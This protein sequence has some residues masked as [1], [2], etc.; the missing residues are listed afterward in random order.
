MS[1]VSLV[2]G[3]SKSN[4]SIALVREDTGASY[5][6]GSSAIVRLRIRKT[7]TIVLLNTSTA[8]VSGSNYI[9]DLGTFLTLNTIS[10]GFYEG[11]IE[12][13]F[14]DGGSSTFQ[15]IFEPITLQVRDQFG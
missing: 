12:I 3:D 11:E 8:T 4:L 14:P 5:F 6:A 13:E 15:T 1:T 2:K 9:F 10:A 7:G